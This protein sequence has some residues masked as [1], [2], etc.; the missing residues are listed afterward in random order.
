LGPQDALFRGIQQLKIAI[1]STKATILSE[2]PRKHCQFP[3]KL[4]NSPCTNPESSP[5]SADSAK[6]RG[7]RHGGIPAR[8]DPPSMRSTAAST[9]RGDGRLWAI[10]LLCSLGLNGA[11]LV[12]FGLAAL[13][14]E[15]FRKVPPPSAP[16]A[17]EKSAASLVMIFPET[18][19]AEPPPP[20]APAS[21]RFART[22]A[23]QESTRPNRPTFTGERNTQATS[24]RPPD[25]SAPAL[26]SQTGS[27]ARSADELAT[28]ESQYREGEIA[29]D[30]PALPALAQTPP[31]PQADP[32]MAAASPATTPPN[33]AATP[34]AEALASASPPPRELLMEGPNPVEIPVPRD[35]A[36]APPNPAPKRTEAT[37]SPAAPE[38][39]RPSPAATAPKP[40]VNDPA[41]RSEQ[42]KTAIRGSISR[43]GRSALDVADSPLGRY[44]AI[45]SRAIEQEW[46]R[47]CARHRDFITP[48]FLTV[49]FFV[50]ATGKVRSV[51]FVGEMETGEVQKGFTLNSIRNAGIPPM[52]PAVKSEL[53]GE[54]LELLFNFY[55]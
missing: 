45:I 13:K 19:P 7:L 17:A 32:A 31:S 51:Q 34:A 8:L 37:A 33:T 2:Q 41:F 4:R 39:P 35:E 22:S 29:D 50:E 36:K 26:P 1:F 48:G 5:R 24:D 44:Q 42:R 54:T 6:F 55:F 20:A 43:K 28:T 11:L 15:F 23:D 16:P 12:V 3:D 47:N 52:P 46:Q 53:D 18:A 30:A 21:K 49:R 25:L 14:S 38:T 9:K 40:K 10:A 27:Q